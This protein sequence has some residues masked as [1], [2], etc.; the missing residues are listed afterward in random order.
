MRKWGL[1]L[2]PFLSVIF[3]LILFQNR[4]RLAENNGNAPTPVVITPTAAPRE[5]EGV[6]IPPEWETYTSDEHG[7]SIQYPADAEVTNHPESGIVFNKIGTTQAMGTELFDGFTV[8]IRQETYTQ[9]SLD[10][11]VRGEHAN[12]TG[13]PATN[14]V[15]EIKDVNL[16]GVS[17]YTFRVSAL[18]DFDHYYL[19]SGNSEYLLLISMVADPT[20]QGYE[21][22]LL[23]M[24]ASL[25]VQ[26]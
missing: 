20:N 10:E 1:G 17:G 23:A 4:E 15:T 6:T 19:P 5:F 26:Q 25:T 8:T 16:A 21:Q 11:F 14:K 3:A 18:G 24:L 22:T 12:M 13:E 7:F 2:I 9:D